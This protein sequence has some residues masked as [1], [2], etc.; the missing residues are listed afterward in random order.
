MFAAGQ[1]CQPVHGRA[2][3]R[4]A[5]R[6]APVSRRVADSH[7]PKLK[8]RFLL[9][10]RQLEPPMLQPELERRSH[11]G[12][13]ALPARKRTELDNYWPELISILHSHCFDDRV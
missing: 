1:S 10:F 2:Q 6:L 7:L 13:R 4:M 11:G 8:L 3:G 5:R 9:V 12:Q